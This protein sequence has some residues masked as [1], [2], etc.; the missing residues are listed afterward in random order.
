VQ[1]YEHVSA[2]PA[3]QYQI[4]FFLSFSQLLYGPR[5]LHILKSSKS[6]L[7]FYPDISFLPFS[8]FVPSRTLLFLSR[9]H[10]HDANTL[11]LIHK[12]SMY[13]HLLLSTVCEC[14]SE[15]SF[16]YIPLYLSSFFLSCSLSL[17]PFLS[18]PSALFLLHFDEFY[19]V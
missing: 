8:S 16:F 12:T 4:F 18:L 5:A 11:K 2:S 3:P 9:S 13:N 17:F 19:L 6:I 14:F 10:P 15:V 7:F 1:L